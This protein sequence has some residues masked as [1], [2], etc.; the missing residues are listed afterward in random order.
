MRT[1]PSRRNHPST[2]RESML[3]DLCIGWMLAAIFSAG[4]GL[5]SATD[6]RS[7]IRRSICVWPQTLPSLGSSVEE[8]TKNR[9]GLSSTWQT[10]ICDSSESPGRM[11]MVSCGPPK[12]KRCDPQHCSQ[13]SGNTESRMAESLSLAEHCAR[14]GLAEGP[15]RSSETLVTIIRIWR[16]DFTRSS[17]ALRGTWASYALNIMRE[18]G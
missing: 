9:I 1:L 16:R 7:S 8:T 15:G 4:S 14:S 17:K 11:R 3:Q 12:K 13:S 6:E 10:N 18:M 2:T 5:S